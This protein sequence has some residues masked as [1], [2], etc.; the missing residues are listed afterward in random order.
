M[1]FV[2]IEEWYPSRSTKFEVFPIGDVHYGLNITDEERLDAAIKYIKGHQYARWI[3]MGELVDLIVPGDRR[4]DNQMLAPWVDTVDVAKS[5]YEYTLDKLMPIKD[6]CWGLLNDNHSE[7][8]RLKINRDIYSDLIRE[9]STNRLGFE[10]F[11]NVSFIRGEQ[12]A[13]ILPTGVAVKSKST[14]IHFW[15]HHGWFSGRLMGETALNLERLAKAYD[16][17]LYLVAHGHKGLIMPLTYLTARHAGVHGDRPI[18]MPRWAM[19]TQHWMD[20][21]K[22]GIP[23]ESWAARRGFWPQPTGCPIIRIKPDRRGIEVA[24]R[25]NL[26]EIKEE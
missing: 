1:Q 11:L 24:L 19:M 15:L 6:K 13:H 25:G 21:H 23:L 14:T 18:S 12:K 3:G 16:A 22:S 10:C 8:M 4:Y 17:D 5:Q 26:T 7:T 2:E 9:L 20:H